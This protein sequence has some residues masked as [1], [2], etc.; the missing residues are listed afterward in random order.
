MIA[1]ESSAPLLVDGL[2]LRNGGQVRLLLANFGAEPQ[3]VTLRGFPFAENTL[4]LAPYTL[5]RLDHPA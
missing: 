3:T 4:T 2:V 1:S 5:L